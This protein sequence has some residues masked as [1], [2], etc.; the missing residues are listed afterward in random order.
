MSEFIMLIFILF[1]INSNIHKTNFLRI[2]KMNY[3]F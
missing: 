3:Y 1:I 2:L